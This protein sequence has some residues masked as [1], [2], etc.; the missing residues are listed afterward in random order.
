MTEEID[1]IA[2]YLSNELS[3]S[4][5]YNIEE[6]K[7]KL[8]ASL[9]ILIN[10]NLENKTINKLKDRVKIHIKVSNKQDI[11]LKFWKDKLR[12]LVN[13]SEINNYY[14]EI[15]SILIEQGYKIKN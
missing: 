5:L 4:N 14:K 11:E 2:K 13:E 12:V 8:K 6:V 10:K 3:N 15:D 9:K 7:L 1:F